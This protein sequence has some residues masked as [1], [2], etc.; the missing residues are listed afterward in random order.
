VIYL[1]KGLFLYLTIIGF[2]LFGLFCWHVRNIYYFERHT[3]EKIKTS[4][5]QE[6]KQFDNTI[7]LVG[8]SSTEYLGNLE[9]L[10]YSLNQYYPG[11]KFLLLNYGYSSTNILSLPERLE[12]N[13]YHNNRIY[14]PINDINFDLILIESFGNNPLTQYPLEVGLQMQNKALDQSVNL[15]TQTH[16]K[17]SIVFVATLAPSQKYYGKGEVELSP[18]KRKEWANIRS[19]YILNHITYAKAHNIPVIDIYHPSQT[20]WGDGNIMY[21]NKLDYIHPSLIGIFFID[22]HIAQFIYKNKLFK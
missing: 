7:V 11:K 3:V 12:N 4:S 19:A 2:I 20:P 18:E 6:P 21:L 15:I 5:R 22:D 13:T 8:D 9:E 14:Q 17:S 16:P 1:N 10:G